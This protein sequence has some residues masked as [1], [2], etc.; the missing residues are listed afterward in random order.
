MAQW[1]RAFASL[2]EDLESVLSTHT[3]THHHLELRSQGIGCPLLVSIG[4]RHVLTTCRQNI[5]KK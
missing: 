3:V 2:A 1:L 4:T 5:Y